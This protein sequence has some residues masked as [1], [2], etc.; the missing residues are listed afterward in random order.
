M[1]VDQDVLNCLHNALSAISGR[2]HE[3]RFGD[4]LSGDIQ[5]SEVGIGSLFIGG[6]NSSGE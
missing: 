3:S 1:M 4:T 6:K 2:S 5:H